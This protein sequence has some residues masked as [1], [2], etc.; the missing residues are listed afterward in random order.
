MRICVIL[1]GCYPYVTGGVSSWIHEYI[2][3]MPQHEF[4]LWTVGADSAMQGQF[5][6]AL[7]EN[8]VEVH[9]VFLQDAL[10]LSSRGQQYRFSAQELQTLHDFINCTRPDWETL[11]RMYAD[12][13]ISPLSFLMSEAFLDIL[14]GICREEYR[15]T[16]FSDFFHTVRSMFLP[17][18]YILHTE[19]PKAD[20]YHAIA[21]G[22][23]GILARLGSY[24]YHVPYLLTEHGIY[25][26]EREEEII[27]AQWVLPA[28]KKYWVRFFY[29]LSAGAYERAAMIS[30]L[31][32]GA[33]RIQIELGCSPERCVQIVN[34]VHCSRFR[35]IPPG[36]ATAP[37]TS[38]R[39]C[40]SPPSRM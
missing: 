17:V 8:V 13:G 26:R 23:S 32:G 16:A 37:S 12:E 20:V 9:E 3:A 10:K 5:K 28:F 35:S 39:C 15:Y 1:E 19:I 6:Y 31:Y 30:S 24:R 38:G 33:R 4:V 7:P 11:F 18:L 34:G 25:T 27:R 22:Y 14:T 29:M 36:A 21:T 2:Q 40:A